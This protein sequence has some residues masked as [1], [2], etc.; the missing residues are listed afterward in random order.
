MG[1]KY[2][3]VPFAPC[4]PPSNTSNSTTTSTT[5]YPK[6]SPPTLTG[7]STSTSSSST[8]PTPLT[9]SG[10]SSGNQVISKATINNTPSMNNTV[11][12]PLWVSNFSSGTNKSIETPT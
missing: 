3:Q 10:T 6:P 8:N 7:T 9:R 4:Y 1:N 5:T 12:T 11:T 2:L